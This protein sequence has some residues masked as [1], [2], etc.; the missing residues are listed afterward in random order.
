MCGIFGVSFT[1]GLTSL[2]RFFP[3][4]KVL[5]SATIILSGIFINLLK[6]DNTKPG[7]CGTG[8]NQQDSVSFVAV[9]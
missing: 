5:S 3:N 8:I 1:N 7:F 2:K 9:G 4:G 6:A